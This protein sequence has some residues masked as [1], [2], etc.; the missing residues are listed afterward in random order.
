LG[1][2]VGKGTPN[3]LADAP[4]AEY[5][6]CLDQATIC[7]SG[8][9]NRAGATIDFAHDPAD[10]ARRLAYPMLVLWSESGIASL[11]DA[12]GVWR[13]EADEV[14]GHAWTVGLPRRGASEGNRGRASGVPRRRGMRPPWEV[15]ASARQDAQIPLGD[16]LERSSRRC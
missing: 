7:A 6:G 11:Y 14:R 1:K 9:D 4:V 2:V 13:E 10:A 12:L 5:R 8:E 15:S 16:P 3:A